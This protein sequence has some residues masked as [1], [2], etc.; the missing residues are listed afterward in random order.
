MRRCGMG[1]AYSALLSS[2]DR[3][4]GSAPNWK[5]GTGTGGALLP[6]NRSYRPR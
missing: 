3:S 5:P 1:N 2:A 6:L 4:S